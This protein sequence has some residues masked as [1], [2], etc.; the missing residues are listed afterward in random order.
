MITGVC[1]V[2][3]VLAATALFGSAVAFVTADKDDIRRRNNNA[4]VAMCSLGLIVTLG[5]TVVMVN[6]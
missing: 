6:Q 4:A 3:A 2:M 1:V 5:M